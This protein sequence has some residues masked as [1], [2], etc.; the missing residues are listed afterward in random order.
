[1]GILKSLNSSFFQKFKNKPLLVLIFLITSILITLFLKPFYNS[2]SIL[3][4]ILA[5]LTYGFKL[6]FSFNKTLIL[7]IILYLIMALTLFWT[8]NFELSLF[9]LKKESVFLFLPLT[10]LFLP[11]LN[12]R[13]VYKIIR[14]YSFSVIIFAIYCFIKAIVNYS[15][16]KTKDVFLF[17]NLVTLDLNAIYIAAFS[18]LSLFYFIILKNKKTIDYFGIYILVLFIT[19]LNSKTVFF[20][21]FILL[22]WYYIFFSKTKSG[23]KSLTI[24]FVG[25]F[26]L[27]SIFFSN[28]LQERIK[29]EYETSFVDNTIYKYSDPNQKAYNVSL[30]Q[31]WSNNEFKKNSF[32]PGT[33]YRV[34][35]VRIFKELLLE[36]ENIWLIG[37]GIN[38]SAQVIK[39]K[40]K[41]HNLFKEYNYHN[42]HNQYIQ[43]FAELGILG[44]II[45]IVMLFLNLKNAIK[46]KD[47][48]HIV[49]AVSMIIL[50]L[51]ESMLSRQR[52]I[53]FF[54]TLY[55]LFNAVRYK[56]D[57]K[58]K[59][60]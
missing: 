5:F 42:F 37:L 59:N 32:F 36:Q 46:N 52:G 16:Y 6:K 22:I 2:V 56:P 33:A 55:C 13:K 8:T 7:P 20:I 38:S 10:F 44:F 26:L 19:L 48:L 40:H 39:D 14:L 4:F 17:H 58:I 25:T 30:H 18:S 34:F 9:G 51:T 1:M 41:Q 50:F 21:D 43:F 29:E 31:A 54:I 11:K 12:S 15:I 45:F 47:F 49:F 60:I 57:L 3:I 24:I 35:Q 23:V 28:Q 27:L 53:V